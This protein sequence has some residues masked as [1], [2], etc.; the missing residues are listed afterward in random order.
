MKDK[1]IEKK[2]NCQEE[3]KRYSKGS[4]FQNGLYINGY[5]NYDNQELNNID[6]HCPNDGIPVSKE[7]IDYLNFGDNEI[8]DNNKNYCIK[9]QN[10]LIENNDEM[11]DC[12]KPSQSSENKEPNV[13]NKSLN[14][15]YGEY[16]SNIV[17]ESFGVSVSLKDK[18]FEDFLVLEEDIEKGN[19]IPKFEDFHNIP[20]YEGLTKKYFD[21]IRNEWFKEIFHRYSFIEYHNEIFYMVIFLKQA[22]IK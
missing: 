6:L 14:T 2:N 15:D 11:K 17:K 20:K 16:T 19:Y 7:I 21:H 10:Q 5:S 1:N 18:L 9:Q 3:K 4:A 12:Y 8:Q 22:L 13:C